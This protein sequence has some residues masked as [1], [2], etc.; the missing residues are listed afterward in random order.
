ME[1]EDEFNEG[2]ITSQNDA[3]PKRKTAG[4]GKKGERL[5]VKTT[6]LQN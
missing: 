4:F 6:L 5:P 1:H 2:A 3:T